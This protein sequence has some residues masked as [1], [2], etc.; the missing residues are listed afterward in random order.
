MTRWGVFVE[1]HIDGKIY[2]LRSTVPDDDTLDIK[3]MY[4]FSFIATTHGVPKLIEC[5][6]CAKCDG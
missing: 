2:V 3:A 1:V 5:L 6:S 4:R